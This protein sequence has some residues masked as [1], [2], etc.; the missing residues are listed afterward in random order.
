MKKLALITLALGVATLGA[1][2]GQLT[3]WNI[4]STDWVIG[5]DGVG[6][7][8]LC[9]ADWVVAVF[10]ENDST[11]G[12]Q[13]DQDTL[14]ASVQMLGDGD[15]APGFQ[16]GYQGAPG[17]D[18][19]DANDVLYCVVF[20]QNS[21][22]GG[23]TFWYSETAG[24]GALYTPVAGAQTIDFGGDTQWVLVPEPGTFALFALGMVALAAG[25]RMRK[26]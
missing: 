14:Y 22:P 4:V 3:F 7:P 10:V 13:W 2:A 23:G 24:S 18:T 12:F 11:A 20:N 15:P 26:K 9:Q 21:V 25:S 6:Q 8:G 19:L 17:F 5:V 16:G 1:T